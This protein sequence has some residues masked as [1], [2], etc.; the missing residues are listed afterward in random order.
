MHPDRK[1]E[2]DSLVGF[3]IADIYTHMGW[4]YFLQL[5]KD[6]YP[7]LIRMFFCNLSISEDRENLV[8]HVKGDE[9]KLTIELLNTIFQSPQTGVKIFLKIVGRFP[10]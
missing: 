8:S 4:R 2:L 5:S 3:P 9:I 10:P 7:H 1:V 6:Y